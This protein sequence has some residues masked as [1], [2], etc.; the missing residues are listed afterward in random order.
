VKNSGPPPL[1][2]IP[3]YIT[4]QT[5][6][7]FGCWAWFGG[8]WSVAFFKYTLGDFEWWLL[9]ISACAGLYGLRPNLER[10][11]D[12]AWLQ[13]IDNAK[14]LAERAAILRPIKRRIDMIFSLVLVSLFLVGVVLM[15]TGFIEFSNV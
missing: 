14:A 2:S 15:F 3:L 11:I 5:L 6:T 10:A 9:V 1:K 7:L 8:L 13:G 12:S 4:L